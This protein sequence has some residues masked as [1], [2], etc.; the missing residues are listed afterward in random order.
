MSQT[1]K[2]TT[3]ATLQEGKSESIAAS[4]GLNLNLFIFQLINF[5]IVAAIVWWLIL[6][7]LVKKMQE[8]QEMVEKSV[9]DAKRIEANLQTSEAKFQEKIDEGKVE[10]NKII[11]KAGEE[12][13]VQGEK[14]REK[15]RADVEQLI[16]QAKVK[17]G[18]EKEK[19]TV[20]LRRETGELVIAA[21]EKV[22]DKTMDKEKD[23]ELVEEVLKKLK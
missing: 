2:I 20:E 14:L 8:R 17:I 7:P 9:E 3:E 15:A 6:K 16:K 21:L 1:N 10:A 5:A 13:E 18:E 11:A 19:M 23:R 22:L 4:L 12:A